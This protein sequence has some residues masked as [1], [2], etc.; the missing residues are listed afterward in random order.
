MHTIYATNV[1]LHLEKINLDFNLLH[2]GI[3]FQSHL[4]QVRYDFR[5]FN[6]NRSYRTLKKERSNIRAMF[7]ELYIPEDFDDSNYKKYNKCIFLS[8]PK[9]TQTINWG[10]THKSFAEIDEFE[11]KLRLKP[12]VIGIYDCR[13]YV[14]DF[15]EWSM[16]KPTPIW[17]LHKIWK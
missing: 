1:F 17:N 11:S 9:Y 16:D 15:S 12:Y 13:H 7:P 10:N 8:H 3:S 14:R 4:K 2:I 5:A 6:G